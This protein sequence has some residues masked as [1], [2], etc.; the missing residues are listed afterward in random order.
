[1]E[2]EGD[3]RMVERGDRMMEEKKVEGTWKRKEKGKRQK[4]DEKVRR[5]KDAGKDK[6]SY[7]DGCR[8]TPCTHRG[9]LQVALLMEESTAQ[10]LLA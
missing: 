9:A 2:R 6:D 5:L 8:S 4:D 7:S 10:C 1:M 3:R